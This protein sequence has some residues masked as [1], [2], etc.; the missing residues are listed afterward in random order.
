MKSSGAIPDSAEYWWP[1]RKYYGHIFK[2]KNKILPHDCKPE[3]AV[4]GKFIR[5]CKTCN[6]PF[7]K[8][9]VREHNFISRS[10]SNARE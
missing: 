6:K 9:L 7:S 10:P 8:R 5:Y 3:G 1:V 2:R 4:N